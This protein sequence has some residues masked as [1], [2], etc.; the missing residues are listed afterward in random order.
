MRRLLEW[1]DVSHIISGTAHVAVGLFCLTAVGGVLAAN[2]TKSSALATPVV[3][4]AAA[5]ASAVALK[6]DLG[7][8]AMRAAAYTLPTNVSNSGALMVS[9][10][11]RADDRMILQ[12]SVV[13]PSIEI[14]LSDLERE[15]RCLVEGIYYEARG[16]RAAGQRAVAEVVLNR[17]VSGRYPDTICGVVY[18][19]VK[20]GQCQF[21]FACTNVMTKPRDMTAWRKAQRMAHYVL[22][23]KLRSSIGAATFYHASYV[24]PYWAPHMVEVAKI[25]QHVFYRSTADKVAGADPES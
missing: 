24:S 13:K 18:Q 23:G 10:V 4:S 2:L 22:S 15:R 7:E 20:S 17:V 11:F 14:K 21:S 6:I 16:E 25:G 19:G 1:L 3:A 12:E 9:A 8:N 5:P